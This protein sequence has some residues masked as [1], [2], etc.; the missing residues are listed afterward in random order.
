MDTRE[1]FAV[2]GLS[3]CVGFVGGVIYEIFAFFRLIFGCGAN[4][5]KLL[6][7]ALDI[8]FWICFTWFALFTSYKLKFPDFR[9]YIWLGY[10]VG[11]I[12]Y[13][14]SLHKI[15]A[16]LEKLCYNKIT[17]WSKRAKNKEKALKREREKKL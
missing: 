16:F 11:G 13:S 5:R 17:Q 15:I 14:K 6:G 3:V 9:V 7:G 2:F 1:Q 10:A 4:R 8:G 12:L